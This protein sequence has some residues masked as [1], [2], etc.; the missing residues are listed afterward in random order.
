MFCKKIDKKR[1][2]IQI[3]L[4]TVRGLTAK[5]RECGEGGYPDRAVDTKRHQT[6]IRVQVFHDGAAAAPK[7]ESSMD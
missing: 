2:Y 6:E 5:H 3:P 7:A 4:P 1:N